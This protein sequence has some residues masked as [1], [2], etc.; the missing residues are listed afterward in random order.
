M[1]DIPPD[2]HSPLEVVDLARSFRRRGDVAAAAALLDAALEQVRISEPATAELAAS[3]G[4][5]RLERAHLDAMTGAVAASDRHAVEALKLFERGDDRGGQAAASMALGD[6]NWQA[7][8]ADRAVAWWQRAA[9][10][11]ENVGNSALAS[12]AL[13]ATALLELRR[14]GTE[15]AIKC[16]AR[17]EEL[18][19]TPVAAAVAGAARERAAGEWVERAARLQDDVARTTVALI[20]ARLA[21]RA[22]RWE[23]ARLLLATAAQ[24][25]QQHGLPGVAVDALRLDAAVARKQGDPRAAVEGLQT[26]AAAAR[27][28]GMTVQAALVDAETV[29]ALADNNE[30]SAAFELQNQQPS[31]EVASLPVV[32][33][34]RLESFAVL[35]RRS[36][37][38]D[39]ARKALREAVEI[40]RARADRVAELGGL[41][42]L[43]DLELAAGAVAEAQTVARHTVD[44]ATQLQRRDLG[45]SAALTELRA[46]ALSTNPA[47][48]ELTQLQR[49]LPVAEQNGSVAQRV[50]ALD[51]HALW[52]ARAARLDEALATAQRAAELAASQPLIRLRGKA[53]VR[54]AEILQQQGKTHEALTAAQRAAELARQAED[55]VAHSGAMLTAGWALRS[56]GRHDESLLA[57]GHAASEAAVAGRHDLAANAGFSLGDGYLVIGRNREARHCLADA[58]THGEKAGWVAVQVKI[59]R[60][61]AAAFAN[62]GDWDSALLWL[63]KAEALDP[64]V[65][66]VVVALDRARLH[67]RQGAHADALGAL[68]QLDPA[69]MEPADRGGYYTA[70]GQA[71]VATGDVDAACEALVTA[72]EQLRDV[73]QRELGAALFLLGQVEGMRGNGTRCG[74]LLGESLVIAAKLGLAE[75]H[76]IRA[77]IE[78]ITKQAEQS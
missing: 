18:S 4:W 60:T 35:S 75:Q 51:L 36:H 64:P 57:L 55:R 76:T 37:H 58:L 39:A 33:A 67:L 66:A 25:A 44:L 38:F 41:T 14:G 68:L 50:A 16:L 47:S 49:W 74:E 61:T 17:A 63:D 72:I 48:D 19:E 22:G 77:V 23:E 45:L 20:R 73:D 5:M 1:T 56:L 62:D 78:R 13:A 53:A 71:R 15:Q 29:L 26:A 70:V 30:W 9:A 24:Q 21:L 43:A 12:R 69:A 8:H 27:R 46:R 31:A 42:L 10:I 2:N 52:L 34:A 40:H 65:A 3:A 32:A 7:G 54:V 6:T 59:C 11:A 28:A